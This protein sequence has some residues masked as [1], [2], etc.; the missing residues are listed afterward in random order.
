[1]S[2]ELLLLS[3]CNVPFCVGEDEISSV[4]PARSLHH[5][6]LYPE[7][8]AGMALIDDQHVTIFDLAASLGM[9]ASSRDEA[10]SFLLFSGEDSSIGFFVPGT[11]KAGF[12]PSDRILTLPESVRTSEI[13]SCVLRGRQLTPLIDIR[14]VG[15]RV[16]RGELEPPRPKL[17][18]SE[19][20]APVSKAET[21]RFFSAGGEA[22]GI[23][24]DD[25]AY[26]P[27]PEIPSVSLPNWRENLSGL[28]LW[29]GEIVPILRI[30]GRRGIGSSERAQGLLFIPFGTARYA[31]PVEKDQGVFSTG[32]CAQYPLPPLCRKDFLA[33][34]VK[35]NNKIVPL[36]DPAAFLA[37]DKKEPAL[38][39]FSEA[40]RPVSGFGAQFRQD[41]VRITELTVDGIVHAVPAEEV[42]EI[43]E[44]QGFRAL[45]DMPAMVRGIALREGRL[46]P[47]LD[48]A[49]LYGKRM[50]PDQTAAMIHLRNGDFEALLPVE[51]ATA[52]R[53]L[54]REMQR[55]TPIAL[56]HHI[57]Y[58]CYLDGP[59]VRLLLNVHALA[60]HF[61][62]QDI[63]E[64]IESIVSAA[65]KQELS[66]A[67]DQ[68]EAP[69][70]AQDVH[71]PREAEK[72]PCIPISPDNGAAIPPKKEFAAEARKPEGSKETVSEEQPQERKVVGSEV[73]GEESRRV[74]EIAAV[75]EEPG[76]ELRTH[77]RE[78]AECGA[79]IPGPS[80][81]E[82][83]PSGRIP[84]TDEKGPSAETVISGQEREASN[85]EALEIE[86]LQ[87]E[88]I[89]E[90]KIPQQ[91]TNSRKEGTTAS[92]E[93]TG[94]PK[95]LTGETAKPAGQP[96]FTPAKIIPAVVFA[97]VV[98]ILWFVFSGQERGSVRPEKT[99]ALSPAKVSPK[100]DEAPL[101]L[102][103]PA[104]APVP[105]REVYVVAQGDTLWSIAKRFTGDPLNYP[106]LARDNSIATPDLIFPGQRIRLVTERKKNP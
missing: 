84:A 71:L 24:G 12:D 21:V 92:A 57:L 99:N 17:P 87:G 98:V 104:K 9:P 35:H 81:Q 8:V 10:G 15:K 41:E 38:Q 55:S 52:G 76:S 5:I 60:V 93:E 69:G 40:Y 74:E 39:D 37:P 4:I 96:L 58:G 94:R 33:G 73:K 90:R 43:L 50:R 95:G 61:E 77:E 75:Q 49:T 56:P 29:E 54:P 64:L 20:A 23:A 88:K 89:Q 80:V 105:D 16:S 19:R 70:G 11:P 62:R 44:P 48:L 91:E 102:N 45:P 6:P 36:L 22:F 106:R 14:E 79:E 53:E 103:V 30:A 28:C 42:K 27:S 59:A 13:G 101:Y 46:L 72:S 85:S 47:V 78:D 25:T 1:M 63:R 51:Q 82:T 68:Q 100:A 34:V 32:E 67:G 18:S 97:A 66:P 2:R 26:A 65:A 86:G 31:T 83:A 7:A 3:L